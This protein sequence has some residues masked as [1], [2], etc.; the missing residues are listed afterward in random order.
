MR[1]E[2]ENDNCKAHG[3]WSLAHV[4]AHNIRD[5]SQLC[6]HQSQVTYSRCSDHCWASWR[7]KLRVTTGVRERAMQA[8]LASSASPEIGCFGTLIMMADP[9]SCT[10]SSVPLGLR[11][12]E[13][14]EKHKM[15]AKLYQVA[16]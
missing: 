13:L 9:M 5:L 6:Y 12:N 2:E 15:F 16:K 1:L 11:C 4:G 7:H 14:Y 3:S 10:S 8:E